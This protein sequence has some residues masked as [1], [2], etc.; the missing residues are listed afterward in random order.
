MSVEIRV[1]GPTVPMGERRRHQAADVD[2]PDALWPCAGEQ[3]ML[4]NEPQRI[5]HRG[6]VRLFDDG[7][8]GGGSDGPQ[9]RDGFDGGEGE[10]W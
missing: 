1:P 2:L 4:L 7:R 9:C 8:H 3:R 10:D 5:L 6:L